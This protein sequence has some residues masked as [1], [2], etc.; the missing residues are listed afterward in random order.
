[1]MIQLVY[2][3]LMEVFPMKKI[4]AIVLTLAMLLS[5]VVVGAS[6][7]NRVV[8]QDDETHFWQ[9]GTGQSWHPVEFTNPAQTVELDIRLDD[10]TSSL[11]NYNLSNAPFVSATKMGLCNDGT[12][13]DVSLEVGTWYTLK[14]VC[15]GSKTEMFVNGTSVG[16]V[17]AAITYYS[18]NQ[19]Y[20]APVLLSMDNVKVG[21]QTFDFEGDNAAWNTQSSQGQLVTVEG[22][23][24]NNLVWEWEETSED[25]YWQFGS[26]QSWHPVKFTSPSQTVELD[27]R[28]DD[29]TSS[30]GNYN[31][32]NAPFVSA[33]KMGLCN[34]GTAVDVNLKVGTWYTLKW[35]CDGSK[36]EMFVDGTSV[37]S[38]NAA[39]SYH[40]D[41]QFYWAPVLLSMDNVKNGD[42]TFDFQ[43]DDH[44]AWCTESS[45]GVCVN[46]IEKKSASE[47]VGTKY[48]HFQTG[49]SWHPVNVAE[50]AT[51]VE[52]NI[53]LDGEDSALGCYGLSNAPYVSA[54]KVGLKDDT[55]AVDAE[56]IPGTW[57]HIKWVSADG[58]TEIF[59]DGVSVGK[60]DAAM[61]RYDNSQYYW[62][63]N[64]LSVDNVRIGEAFYDFEGDLSAWNEASVQGES[65]AYL[66]KSDSIFD[67]FET[68]AP[69]GEAW[70]ISAAYDTNAYYYAIEN[71]A[72]RGTD[73]IMNF[74]LK[75]I[76]SKNDRMGAEQEGSWFE[77]WLDAGCQ[78]RVQI[79]PTALG[80]SR[81]GT[82]DLNAFAYGEN[83]WHNVTVEILGS[84]NIIRIYID[85]ELQY[86][87]TA[88][89]IH[90]LDGRYLIGN[91]Y[92]STAVLD[93]YKIYA[94][95]T[96]DVLCSNMNESDAGDAGR[97]CVVDGD[98]ICATF[99]PAGHTEITTAETCYS[100]GLDTTYCALCD[101]KDEH[102][103]DMVAH[104]WVHYDINRK[105]DSGLV[106]N[107]CS[108]SGCVEKR[109]TKL[110]ANYEGKLYQY[111]DMTDDLFLT[112]GMGPNSIDYDGNWKFED[113]K[114][115]YATI[116][117]NYNQV[118]YES[119][120]V[121]ANSWSWW[122]DITFTGLEP[123]AEGDKYGHEVYF[124][125]G[126]PSNMFF[127]AGYNF[128]KNQFFIRP[129]D[130]GSFEEITAD[131]TLEMNKSYNFGITYE[132]DSEEWT[133]GIALWLDGEEVC[134]YTD[135]DD[136]EIIFNLEYTESNV[137]FNVWRDFS[138]HSYITSLAIGSADFRIAKV[139][140]DVDNDGELTASDAVVYRRYLSAQADATDLSKVAHADMN[141]DK[142]VNAKD[143]LAL[144]Q[145]LAA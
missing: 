93:N 77:F 108:A 66:L 64:L 49:N 35:V 47:D 116:D 85:K 82:K 139:L 32:S 8:T 50:E 80:I 92:G 132:Y 88:G 96:Y 21:G 65:L 60:V 114:L 69:A 81:G 102:V 34:D 119:T 14:W 42:Q 12:A 86:E 7:A 87:G 129:S 39:I 90:W 43:T 52:M 113:G 131:V 84:Y 73:M 67:K 29:A 16:S 54:T 55:I 98:N 5:M 142:K 17:N 24:N 25:K 18:N 104:S 74:D 72:G 101:H 76:P 135:A 130:G 11:G 123:L 46:K 1:M 95:K 30:L 127:Q 13:V 71:M 63:P 128:D 38:V 109:Y 91:V 78:N 138:V 126:G 26:G 79:S 118:N 33:T 4:L 51:V 22:A 141:G 83:T 122:M 110:P 36:T 45:Q 124:W 56:I 145:A 57:Y 117:R 48:Y 2:Q 140:G 70:A 37:G 31:L 144:R 136:E 134:S 53:N 137:G 44:S 19:F 75:L 15:D 61:S 89:S 105:T 3:I 59:V 106:Y 121:A 100:T 111:Y 99:H 97:Y 143:L 9:F 23:L 94:T 115:V 133:G 20:W 112:V 6:A 120:S 40:S 27:I 28:L 68:T 62:A 125:T 58:K 41:N 107:Y 103:I 10:A